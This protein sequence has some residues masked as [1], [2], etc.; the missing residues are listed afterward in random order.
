M[1]VTWYWGL[2]RLLALAGI[3]F[4]EVADLFYAWLRGERRLWFIP[5]VDDATGLKPAVLVGRTDTGEVLVVLAR[6][7]GRDIYIINASRPSTELMADFEAW[8]ARND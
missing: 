5:A 2:A 7:D 4:D 3:D 6:I 1:A 8:E